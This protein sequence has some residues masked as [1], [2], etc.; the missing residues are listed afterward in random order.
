MGTKGKVK[1]R[2]KPLKRRR[3]LLEDVDPVHILEIKDNL[4]N[5]T[6]NLTRRESKVLIREILKEERQ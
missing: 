6:R 2:D 3:M 1:K 5:R 4:I